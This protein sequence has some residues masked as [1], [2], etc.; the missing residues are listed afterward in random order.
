MVPDIAKEYHQ[1]KIKLAEQY[2]Y[3]R[4]EYTNAKGEFVNRILQLVK[5]QNG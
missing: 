4:E 3:D 2:I 5:N 1:L